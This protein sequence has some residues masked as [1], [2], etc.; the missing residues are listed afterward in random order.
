MATAAIAQDAAIDEVVVTGSRIVRD[1]YQAPTPTT[2]VGAE[3]L[4]QRAP[5]TV[6][7]A[8]ATLPV[9][10]GISNTSSGA[11]TASGTLGASFVNAR[12]LGATRTLVMLNG[13][14][15][16]PTAPNGAVDVSVLPSALIK[17][18]DVVTGGASAAYGSDAVAG[19]VDFVLDTDYRGL[20]GELQ[21][22]ISSRGDGEQFK[23]S[24]TAGT[25]IGDRLSLV[26]SGEYYDNHGV[27]NMS[28][29]WS[30]HPQ[31][32]VITNTAATPTNGLS[33][34]L[35]VPYSYFGTANYGGLI[36]SGPLRG[37]QFLPN[38]QTSQFS[39]CPLA[40]VGGSMCAGE[41]ADTTFIEALALMATPQ[42]RANGFAR[43]TY[44]VNDSLRIYGDVLYGRSKTNV[45]TT[46]PNT[47]AQGNY[48]IQIDNA[49]LPASVR[50]AMV[51]A[52]VSNF[53][54]G[55]VSEDVAIPTVARD[56]ETLRFSTGFEA[57]LSGGW[58]LSGYAEHGKTESQYKASNLALRANV[59]SAL[60]SVID[61]ATGRPVCRSTLTS[62]GN[63]CVPVNFFGVGSPSPEAVR[64]LVGD[65]VADL[66]YRQDAA[67][68]QVSGDPVTLWAGPVSLTAGLEWRKQKVGQVAD[69]RSQAGLFVTGNPKALNGQVTV[70]EAFGEVV[71]PIL[72]DTLVRSLDVNAA[73][74]VTDYSTSGRVTTWKLG[75]TS[76]LNDEV[77]LRTTLSRDIRAPNVIELF[78]SSLLTTGQFLDPVTGVNSSVTSSST[79]N[80][81]LQPEKANTFSAGVVYR[82]TWLPGLSGSVDF[83]RIEITG[84]IATLSN[85]DL[86]LRCAQGQQDLCALITRDT[87]GAVRTITSPTLNLAET[88]TQGIDIDASYT[89]DI[90]NLIA[91]WSGKL[92]FRVLGNYIEKLETFDGRTRTDRAGSLTNGQ[93]IW[94]WNFMAAYDNGPFGMSANLNRIGAGRYDNTY[95]APTQINLN[96]V[97]PEYYLDI[98]AHYKM[99][100]GG[101]QV[102][103]FANVDNVFDS[104]PSLAFAFS[105][106]S[107]P[108]YPRIGRYYKAG[109][110]FEF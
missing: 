53:T 90:S 71:V 9:F 36:N 62:P 6:I 93:P 81:N 78:S 72:K 14:R 57:K 105:Q 110:R 64:Y 52:G 49:F 86:V 108:N 96:H 7:D 95:S 28:R 2:V 99:S 26:A 20:R 84:A 12:G 77:S 85:N 46:P 107:G 68:L 101:H 83:Y 35:V 102:Q 11:Q 56:N 87:T 3:L 76:A 70:K 73:G 42:E 103:Y 33:Q 82:P 21:G 13:Q 67:S 18:I 98:G 15:I 106:A 44:D 65:S 94:S 89:T 40:A 31:W 47:V 97:K 8:L 92:V 66:D 43:A 109:L 61:P 54:L 38:G 19:V 34:R 17:R 91:P 32:N 29:P 30:R 5:S 4:Q 51:A 48:T 22:G 37:L 60:D 25:R 10:R 74:R 45:L 104:A 24:L 39:F 59:L 88:V 16:V 23:A 41:R 50:S 1:G 55:R 79:G 63:G 100:V 80:P 58:L 27:L 69:A 75:A